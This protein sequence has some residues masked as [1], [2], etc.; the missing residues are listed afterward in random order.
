MELKY[1][2]YDIIDRTISI[3]VNFDTF[4]VEGDS[5]SRVV[6]FRINRY[7]DNIDLSKKNIF[8]CFKNAALETGEDEV[9]DKKFTN[10]ILTF[11]WAVPSALASSAGT[12][13]LY[14]EFRTTDT[15]GNI[16]YRL[17]TKP[18]TRV[19]EGTF[20]IYNNATEYDY[21]VENTWLATNTDR[22]DHVDLADDSLPIKVKDRDILFN[23]T[24]TIAV[25]NDE[26]SQILSFRLK[27]FVNGIDRNPFTIAFCFKNAA[28]ESDMELGCNRMATEDEIFVSWALD[29]RV[30][31][32]PGVVSFYINILGTLASGKKYAWQTNTAS[33]AVSD[34]LD[35]ENNLDAP[36]SKWYDD[37][38]I[39]VDNAIKA[40][41]I[42]A[43]KADEAYKN[44]LASEGVSETLLQSCRDSAIEAQQSANE[45]KDAVNE[46]S[47]LYI[48]RTNKDQNGLF[49]TVNYSRDDGT[50]FMTSVLQSSISGATTYDERIETRYS[51]DGNTV[52]S[53]KI[54]PILYDIDGSVT[55]R[56]Y[57]LNQMQ[58]HGLI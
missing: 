50:L 9:T 29:S 34:T 25:K 41:S 32:V 49:I 10:T 11:G 53:T 33:F 37:L 17:K 3:P 20:Y 56:F 4:G 18:I 14:I 12:V 16:V 31:K 43:K 36:P 44:V 42:Y 21:H 26:M 46:L 7:V 13:E 52:V 24:K 47:K 57:P 8:V 39:E 38:L 28:G 45:A 1:N 5:N 54:C 55:G 2:T 23:E 6:E 35:I 51:L 30:T 58:Y 19:I 15:D 40:A 27:R 48:E 22:V